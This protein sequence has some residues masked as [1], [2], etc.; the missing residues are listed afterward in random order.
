[1][2]FK[3]HN[4]PHAEYAEELSIRKNRI[5]TLIG[6][7]CRLRFI[8]RLNP[9]LVMVNPS[10]CF[11]GTPTEQRTCIQTWQAIHPIGF[12]SENKYRHT[13]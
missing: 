13:A 9:R 7:L 6:E 5:S 1:M 8:A 2:R 12:V 10:W 4:N 11:R 3:V